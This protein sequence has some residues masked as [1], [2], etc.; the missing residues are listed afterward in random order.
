MRLLATNPLLL[1]LMALLYQLNWKLPEQRMKL[2]EECVQMLIAEWDRWRGFPRGKPRFSPVYKRQVLTQVAAQ[3]HPAG[4]FEHEHLLACLAKV[5]PDCGGDNADP[6]TFLNEVMEY[7][8]LLQQ[9]SRSSYSFVHL[10]FQEF[11]TACAWREHEDSEALLAHIGN[12]SWKEVIRLYAGLERDATALLARLRSHDLLL[13]A[14]CLADCR[15][16]DTPAFHGVAEEIVGDLE[17][18][19]CH[20]ATQ[21]QNAADALD[22]IA[23]WGATVFLTD[24][25]AQDDSQPTVALAAL[26]ALARAADKTVLDALCTDVGRTLCLLHGQL[27][28]VA[29]PLRPRLLSLLESLGHPLVFVPAGEF[30]M[31]SDSGL[32]NERPRHKVILGDYWIDKFPVTN[33]QFA[34]FVQATGYKAQGNWQIA[35]TSG[36]EQHPVVFVT[37]DDACAYGQWCGKRLPTEA[38]WE[39]AARGTDGREYPWSNQWDGNK[40]NASGREATPVGAYPEGVSPY[41]CHDMVGN[42]WEWCQD[43]Y[44]SES[45]GHH[46]GHFLQQIPYQY[47]KAIDVQ[48]AILSMVS[49]LRYPISVL[50]CALHRQSW[51][52]R[53]H[54]RGYSEYYQ[55]SPSRDPQGPSS[56]SYRVRRG[57]S[58]GN[59]AR[60]CRSACRLGDMSGFGGSALGFRLLTSMR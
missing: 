18:L 39:K 43:W 1:S 15:S 33:V 14:A 35:F 54:D 60:D 37:W 4:V 22:E 13:A 52:D 57:G 47:I 44:D 40:C 11:F 30:L 19:V 45:L 28:L 5:L 6:Q 25:V 24:A 36:K 17:H 26:L 20:D 16:V 58:W 50:R 55:H 42:V 46:I 49:S 12:P 32:A 10:T 29:P 7:T 56:G 38:E 23:G 8:G 59:S 53:H 9:K 51:G 27:P 2:Y 21:R 41:G 31:G 48:G 3:F 34:Q